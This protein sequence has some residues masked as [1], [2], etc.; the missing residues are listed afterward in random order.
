MKALELADTLRAIAERR[1][2]LRIAGG[3]IP[4]SAHLLA[5]AAATISALVAERDEARRYAEQ[6]AVAL[7]AKHYP[8]VPQWN[9][10]TGDLWGLISQIDNMTTG[11]TRADVTE[12]ALA[13]ANARIAGLEKALGEFAEPR[14]WVVNGRFDPHSG[15]FDATTFA[16]A[17]LT[18]GEDA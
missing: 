13:T 4:C 12:P 6:L 10:L 18:G 14:N 5:E 17:A 9:P 3:G 16:R 11:L 8:D 1:V 2:M 15:N 7:A